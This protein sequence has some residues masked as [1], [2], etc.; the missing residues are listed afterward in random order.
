MLALMPWVLSAFLHLGVALIA[1][2]VTIVHVAPTKQPPIEMPYVNDENFSDDPG[3]VVNPG[4]PG[5]QSE[6]HQH[7]RQDAAVTGYSQHDSEVTG[8]VGDTGNVA[9]II[10]AGGGGGQVGG[11]GPSTAWAPAA[12]GTG[13]DA[14]L[15][16]T[17]ETRTT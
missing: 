12:A 16:G 14:P 9:S 10:S 6:A 11:D 17:A 4:D 5:D 15:P 2:F 3:G 8:S 1:A 13:P 7:V